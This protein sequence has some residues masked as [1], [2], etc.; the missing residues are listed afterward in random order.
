MPPSEESVSILVG[1]VTGKMLPW[2]SQPYRSVASKVKGKD[3]LTMWKKALIVLW[4]VLYLTEKKA[5]SKLHRLAFLTAGALVALVLNA[6]IASI[7]NPLLA[8]LKLQ[9]S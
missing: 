4:P 9:Y 6:S 1:I 7:L 3:V 2:M 8:P 5:M